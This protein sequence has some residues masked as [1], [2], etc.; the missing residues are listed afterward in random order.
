MYYF[1]VNFV[2]KYCFL[3]KINF[4][5]AIFIKDH[6]ITHVFLQ[7]IMQCRHIFINSVLTNK[8]FVTLSPELIRF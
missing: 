4:F 3:N 7:V 5:K 6:I 1:F 8:Y 2:I